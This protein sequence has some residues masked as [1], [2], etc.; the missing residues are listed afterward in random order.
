[1]GKN[2]EEAGTAGYG[3]R[4]EAIEIQL[5]EKG[6]DAPGK[7]DEPM[8]QRLV[9]YSSHIQNTGNQDYV[10]DG[11]VSGSVGKALRME[12]LRIT[13]PSLMNSSVNYCAHVQ[14]IG[15]QNWVNKGQ[16]A[17]TAGEKLRM[18][19]V[20]LKLSGKAADKYDIYYQVHVQNLG[21]LDWAKNGQPA[22]TEGYS[23]RMEGIKIKLV[24]K[25][26]AA[27]GSTKTPFIKK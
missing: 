16:T 9:A 20:K 26:K 5:I 7:T 21:W 19:A 23:Y 14:N 17:G 6:K 3:Y 8:K 10:Y 27:P 1:M 22:G 12:A 13:L 11:E 24:E 2:G 4:L 25:G 18:E 15:W